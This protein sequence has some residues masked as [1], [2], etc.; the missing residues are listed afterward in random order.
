MTPAHVAQYQALVAETGALY[1]AR[2]YRHYDFLLTLSDY[3]AHF[4]LEHHESSD[5]RVAERSLVDEDKRA[6]CSPAC[7]PTR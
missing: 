6:R 1:G 5:D 2:H 7:C 4:G 3:T